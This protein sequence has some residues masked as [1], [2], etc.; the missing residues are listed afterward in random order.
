MQ[1]P[2]PPARPPQH[3]SCRPNFF[4]DLC[5]DTF[6]GPWQ[7][8]FPPSIPPF[9]ISDDEKEDC[10][11]LDTICKGRMDPELR[12]DFQ[13]FTSW[14]TQAIQLNRAS[15][16]R[17][18]QAVTMDSSVKDAKLFL[19]FVLLFGEVEASELSFMEFANPCGTACFVAYLLARE[20]SFSWE[21]QT[22]MRLKHCRD[23]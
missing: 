23:E 11:G 22:D 5:W 4:N 12:K 1:R 17:A 10:Y 7:G 3:S 2:R 19:G 8:R 21:A 16:Y 6:P 18:V 15:T 20:V 14:C 13:A 9:D